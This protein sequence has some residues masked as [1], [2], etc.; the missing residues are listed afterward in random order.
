MFMDLAIQKDGTLVPYGSNKNEGGVSISIRQNP[1][2]YTL[3]LSYFTTVNTSDMEEALN[4]FCKVFKIDS[5][6]LV[7]VQQVEDDSLYANFIVCKNLETK[8][9]KRYYI[10]D[11]RFNILKTISDRV[12]Q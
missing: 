1:K 5:S 3:P 10:T 9:N 12:Q 8:E 4:L 2:K 11:N 7:A 6:L